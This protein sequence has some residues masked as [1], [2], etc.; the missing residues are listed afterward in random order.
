[1]RSYASARMPSAIRSLM[2]AMVKDGGVMAPGVLK[3]AGQHR[4]AV[5]SP[6]IVDG[7]SDLDHD[8]AVPRQHS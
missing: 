2:A 5:E 8:T 6:L 1:M 7:Q 3:G 4:E